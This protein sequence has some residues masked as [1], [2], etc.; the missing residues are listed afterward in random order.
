MKERHVPSERRSETRVKA[1]TLVD[2]GEFNDAGLMTGLEIG[3]TLDLTH[4][5]L[6]LE[7][8]H[9]ID[10]GKRVVM[11]IELG[12]K[13]VELRGKVV[14]CAPTDDAR[15]GLGVE[16]T[17]LGPEDYEWLDEFVQLHNGAAGHD[18]VH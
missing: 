15:W 11:D 1:L 10:V 2:V 4:E 17:D 9:P 7:L 13:I 16:F 14:S 18:V 6:R 8:S 12:E 3:R 5:G